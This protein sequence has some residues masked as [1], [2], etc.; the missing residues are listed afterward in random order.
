[1]NSKYLHQ[2]IKTVL[3]LGFV[4]FST[5]QG[6]NPLILF[7][8]NGGENWKVGSQEI[9]QWLSNNGPARVNLEFSVDGGANWEFINTNIVNPSSGS[10]QYVWTIPDRP[11]TECLVKVSDAVDGIPADTSD[12]PFT[13]SRIPKLDLIRPNGGEIWQVGTPELIQWS[14][15]VSNDPANIKIE[16]SLDAGNNW[17]VIA[18]SVPNRGE[19]AWTP[20]EPSS[21][22]CLLAIS[23]VRDGVPSDTSDATFTIRPLP[24]LTVVSPNGGESYLVGSSQVI[25][26]TSRI[27]GD[28]AN[29]SLEYSVN[30]GGSWTIIEASTPND[31]EYV[32]TIPNNPSTE[33]LVK[34][35]DATDDDPTDVSNGPFTIEVP[36]SVTVTGPA[37]GQ[38]WIVG[39]SHDI[40]WTTTG[41][42]TSV[43]I[44][45]SRNNGLSWETLR[46][47]TPNDGLETW[48]VEMP[49][50]NQ[51]RIKI[52]DSQDP[53]ISG[54]SSTFSIVPQTVTSLSKTDPQP[55][56]SA[57][58]A[59]RLLSVPLSLSSAAPKDVLED[60]LGTYD[61]TKWRFFDYQNGNYVEY[62]NA[63]NFAPGRSFFLIV[64]DVGKVITAGA[65]ELVADSVVNVTL[66]A[67]WNFIANPF[68]FDIPVS[69]LS[70]SSNL[71]TYDG[72]WSVPGD[73]TSL[74]PWEG[75]ALKVESPANLAIRPNAV[76]QAL[77]KVSGSLRD[78][79][80]IRI[81][82]EC[83]DSRDNGNFAGVI[84]DASDEWDQHDYYEPPPI[85]DYVMLYFPHQEWSHHADLYTGDFRAGGKDGYVWNFEIRTP[86]L[87]VV[88]LSFEGL[89]DVPAEFEVRLVDHALLQA[90]DL[91]S[92][93]HYSFFNHSDQQLHQFS[94]VAGTSLFVQNSTSEFKSVVSDYEL[95]NNF[96]NP[97]NLS[98]TIGFS[99]PQPEK[100]T[101]KIFNLLG[102]EVATLLN[103]QP[104]EAGFHK[105]Y[106]D[107]R[108]KWGKVVASGIYLY[109]MDAGTFSR[110]RKMLLVK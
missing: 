59:Y 6:Q 3:L 27:S 46:A 7:A 17:I 10:A 108:N 45:L 4:L 70:I 56:G 18:G 96:P 42:V 11:S 24:A 49:R 69:A 109:R 26:W 90:Q 29:V 105:A 88:N 101:L 67:G 79:W 94:L 43:K 73:V 12:A 97:F 72:T 21:T 34:V 83:Q 28:P 84:K 99:L 107:G 64:K 33:C 22:T 81:K 23:D 57:Q 30:G 75:Y 39:S 58:S 32:W 36:M 8:P 61:N 25:R 53:G 71:I 37:S 93:N 66:T 35:S 52:S 68:N 60:D 98:T 14:S 20:P 106:W 100:I 38:S 1:M 55:S 77:T 50:S 95:Y 86:I 104:L 63:R 40:T 102:E 76:G 62:A 74:A 85:G 48:V 65:G 16:Y 5:G 78:D 54:T 47:S 82:A 87:D 92:I 31:D 44:E 19:Y 51:C 2:M 41:A 103:Q 15:V 91:K 110:T 9:I 89:Q 13:I 80:A